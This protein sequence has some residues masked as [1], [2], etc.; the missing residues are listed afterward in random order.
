M[1]GSTSRMLALLS[2][3]QARRDWPGA[4]LA[5]RLGVSGRTVRR[6]VERLR[7]LGY[8]IGAAKGPD[9]GYRLAAGEELPPLLFDDEQAVAIAIALRTVASTGVDVADAA[10]RALATVSQVLPSRLRHRIDGIGISTE[11]PAT[12]VDPTVLHAVGTAVRDRTTL[13]FGYRDP[14]A[15]TRRTHPHAIVARSGRWYLVA[16]DLDRDD[17]RIFRLDRMRPTTPPGARFDPRPLPEGDARDLL[18]ARMKGSDRRN[19][20][21]CVGEIVIDRPADEIAPWIGD[22]ELEQ[23][24]DGSCALRI[25]SWSWAGVLASV[26]RFDAPFEIVGPPELGEAAAVLAARLARRV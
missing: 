14:E 8:R 1:S 6:D 26:V 20:W 13:R 9:G 12:P 21:P 2:L 10:E 17:W 18:E 15:P 3:L 4:V 5:H 19:R 16:W 22:G 24:D 7:A 25:G 11:T 23:R